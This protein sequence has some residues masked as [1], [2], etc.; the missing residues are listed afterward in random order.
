M[1]GKEKTPALSRRLQTLCGMV[2]PGKTVVDV[3]CDHGYADIFLI[4]RGISPRVL[5]MDV[6]EGPLTGA[7]EHVESCGLEDYIEIR[8]SDGLEAYRT[9]EAQVLICAG[10]GGRLMR[11]I[12]ERDQDKMEGLEE[13][14]LQP[15][16]E[17]ADFREFL[18]VSGY[19][20]L[21]EAALIEGGK[22]YFPMKAVP[23][24]RVDAAERARQKQMFDGLCG[25]LQAS[26][27]LERD[28]GKP[29][30]AVTE[31]CDAFG[32]GLLWERNDCLRSYLAAGLDKLLELDRELSD[33]D[34]PGA[35]GRI[36]TL[37]AETIKYRQALVLCEA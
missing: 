3:G 20:L 19:F 26:G 23:D 36:R 18:R 4:R 34:S 24:R 30:N 29:E 16:S 25:R 27:L 37:K 1:D 6:R 8:L 28:H 13:L 10:M 9:G 7:R 35:K 14:I 22:Y 2:T 31:L 32:M 15:Q 5:A 12:L 11:R 17:L 33:R 21:R